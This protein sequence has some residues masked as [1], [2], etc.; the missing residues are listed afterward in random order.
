MNIF[1]LTTGRSGSLSFDQACNH[2]TNFSSA[3]ESRSHLIGANHFN[4]P[5]DHIEADN[6]LTWFLGTLDHKFG[7]SS[8]YVHLIRDEEATAKSF[9]NRYGTGIIRAYKNAMLWQSSKELH[10]LD[11]CRDYYRTVNDNIILFL[12]DKPNKMTMN[13]ETIQED[14]PEFWKWIG[15]EGDLSAAMAEWNT[16]KNISGTTPNVVRAWFSK[17][18]R[19]IHK[20]PEFLRES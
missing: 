19:I 5:I 12:K 20:L 9:S 10:P 18:Q 1:I 8:Y 3:H 17:T 11:V 14:F 13:L 6:R 16:P 4:Y 7:N 2:I 15:A